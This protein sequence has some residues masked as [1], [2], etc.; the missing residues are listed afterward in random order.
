M[1]RIAILG[2]PV[3]SGNRGVLALGSSLVGLCVSGA[4]DAQVTL[5]LGH[6]RAETLPYRVQG[7]I[8]EVAVVP[9]RLSPR[10]RCRDH[11]LWIL[12]AAVLYRLLPFAW[13]RRRLARG[14]PWIGAIE[15]ADF[16]G[17]IRGGD[18]FSDIYGI[19]RLLLGSAMAWTVILVKGSIVQLPQTF[20]PYRSSLGRAVARFLLR[21]S[22][23]IVARDPGSQAIA[24]ELA[25]PRRRVGLCPDVAFSLEALQPAAIILDPPF[26]GIL[27][28]GGIG[29]NV[30]GLMYRGG[31]TRKNMFG[32][33][34]DYAAF[35]PALI[36]VLSREHLGEIWLVPHTYAAAGE[37]ESDPEA[38]RN[39]RASLPPGLRE[40]VRIVAAEYD[41][42]EIKG[43]IGGCDFF[44]GSRMHS[45]IAALSQGIPCVGIAYSRKFAGVFQSIGME[46]WV[47]D[48]RETTGEQAVARVLDLYRQRDSVRDRLARRAT[49]ARERLNEVFR[50]LVISQIADHSSQDSSPESHGITRGLGPAS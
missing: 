15:E 10:S 32:L 26:D 17:D 8:R 33:K 21:R 27:A 29:L 18:S 47:I 22:S 44:I 19:R 38:C 23:A 13:F 49:E 46:D 16:V 36:G 35:L 6:H 39:V 43:I 45:C 9:C 40:R 37:V 48:G 7:K 20:G 24:Q 28:C 30:N 50:E 3:S 5:L 2:T 11:L 25:G 41:Q 14:T 42:H 12:I 4:P 31:Y 1:M 34:L